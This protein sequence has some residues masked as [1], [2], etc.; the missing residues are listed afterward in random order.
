MTQ[1]TSYTFVNVGERTNVTGS[2]QF[3]KLIKENRYEEA[4]DVARQ[5]V[6]N[7]AQILDV[8]MD[9]GLIDSEAAMVRFLNLI[10]AVRAIIDDVDY[11]IDTGAAVANPE[12]AELRHRLLPL[13][14]MEDSLVNEFN[15]D[16]GVGRRARPCMRL[17]SLQDG[18]PRLP[19][20][21]P[22]RELVARTIC[23]SAQAIRE[24]WRNLYVQH[25][26]RERKVRVDT[27]LR[28][29]S[30]PSPSLWYR[31]RETQVRDRC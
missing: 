28:G 21:A 4:V 29:F 17:S 22:V 11:A 31:L 5:Q 8:N 1:N 18:V 9:E 3:R 13:I 23:E 2:A 14:S 16:T 25:L 19:G 10:A 7:G 27:T 30:W 15:H 20:P 12:V 24:L 26:V 6:A